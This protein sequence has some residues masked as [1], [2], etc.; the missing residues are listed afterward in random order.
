MIQKKQH[1]NLMGAI[2]QSVWFGFVS[3]KLA[4]LQAWASLLA[5]SLLNTGI[6]Y[7]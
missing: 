7:V 6:C 5:A 3:S 2:D 1:V 4:G